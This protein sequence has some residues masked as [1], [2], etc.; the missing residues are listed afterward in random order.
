M[1]DYALEYRFRPCFPEGCPSSCRI[2]A[3]GLVRP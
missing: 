2:G 3:G 1:I